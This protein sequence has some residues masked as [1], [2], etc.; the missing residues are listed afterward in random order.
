MSRCVELDEDKPA[1]QAPIVIS[2]EPKE[3]V[4]R[5]G[6]AS[7]LGQVLSALDGLGNYNGLIIVAM[8]NSIESLP[9]PL[10][11]PGRLTPVLFGPCSPSQVVSM[12]KRTGV[13]LDDQDRARLLGCEPMAHALVRA[14]IDRWDRVDA[15]RLV[16]DLLCRPESKPGP[17][18][19]TV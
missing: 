14:I 19:T 18:A 7:H 13:S 12:V 6:R 17:F 3:S 10:I 16:D 2:I 8:T 11:R 4:D 15:S 1:R 9:P 5:A